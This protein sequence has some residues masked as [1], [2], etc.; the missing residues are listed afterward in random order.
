MTHAPVARLRRPVSSPATDSHP[1]V[2]GHP[3]VVGHVR[4]RTRAAG[5]RGEQ[6]VTTAEYA[7]VAAAGCGFGGV[8]LKLLTSDWGQ[9]LLKGLF[10]AFLS[11]I[12]FG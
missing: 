1:S 3:R 4:I 10:D 7:V 9:G 6:G 12:G 5:R 8:L 11:M 2:V